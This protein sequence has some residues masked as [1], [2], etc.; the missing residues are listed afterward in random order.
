MDVMGLCLSVRV[1][2]K[3]D[4]IELNHHNSIPCERFVNLW[5]TGK[6]QGHREEGYK[7]TSHSGGGMGGNEGISV[8]VAASDG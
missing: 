1:P 3:S 2:A 6:Q 5:S 8:C 7:N 4:R